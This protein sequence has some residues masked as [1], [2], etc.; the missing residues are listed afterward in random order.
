VQQAAVYRVVMPKY[1][2][3]MQLP[4]LQ[5]RDFTEHDNEQAPPAVII[6]QTMAR[7]FWRSG[8][9]LGKVITM[10]GTG[11][12]R[13]RLTIVGVA[14]DAKQD[15][16][17]RGSQDEVYLPYLQRPDS[18]GLKYL[19]FVARTPG[20]PDNAIADV[21]QAIWGVDRNLPVS[22]I[23]SMERV[24]SNELWRARIA[25]VLLGSFGAIALVLAAL[26]IYGVISYQMARRTQEIGIRMALGADSFRVL[27]L[28]IYEGMQPVV[29]G[30]IIGVAGAFVATRSM[31][32]LLYDVKPS[33]PLTLSAV[34]SALL[35]VG[36]LANLV[37]ALRASRLNPVTALRHE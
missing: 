24:I 16:W 17:T 19:T 13:V 9:P 1:F 18:M 4:L 25:T 20:N 21:Q 30:A 28:A 14:A 27:R 11:G 10:E 3:S 23:Q 2:D 35:L 5:G 36:L 32:S 37:P 15:D 8:D 33:D 34:T 6:N 26:G 31:E 7:H 12:S 29:L 22:R